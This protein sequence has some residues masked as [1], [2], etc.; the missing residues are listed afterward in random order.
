MIIEAESELSLQFSADGQVGGYGGCNR[1]FGSYTLQDSA[2]AIGPLGASRRACPEPA[3][4]MEFAFLEALQSVQ[5][6]ENARTLLAVCVVILLLAVGYAILRLQ[7]SY[8]ELNASNASLEQTNATLEERV[9]ARTEQLS[10]AYDEL[11]ESQVQ[12]IQAEK[13]SSLGEMVAG[14][15]NL[16]WAVVLVIGRVATA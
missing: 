9:L 1:F 6:A 14:F 10:Q 4:S 15:P 16:S 11:K 8:R 12:L 3:G 7:S 2:L 13:M 5:R